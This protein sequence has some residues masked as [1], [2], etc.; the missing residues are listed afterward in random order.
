MARE[1]LIERRRGR[2]RP[3]GTFAR[4]EV[5]EGE[6][7]SKIVV[8]GGSKECSKGESLI[9]FELPEMPLSPNTTEKEN[10]G[11]LVDSMDFYSDEAKTHK[12]SIRITRMPNRAHKVQ[13]FLDDNIEIRNSSYVS[14]SSGM[15][16]WKMLKNCVR[17]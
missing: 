16:Y 2:G 10:C 17:K 3:K 15:A 9:Q 4:K 12:I 14:A 13:I 1:D 6:T 7:E 11:E 8:P 5:I